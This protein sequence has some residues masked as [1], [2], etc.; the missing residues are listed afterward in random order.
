MAFPLALLDSFTQPALAAMVERVFG[1]PDW[2][3]RLIGHPVGWM[4]RFI[5]M[6]DTKMNTTPHLRGLS[7][8]NGILAMVLLCLGVFAVASVL[9][10]LCRAL[11]YG[12][13]LNA[14]LATSLIATKSLRSHVLA[15]SR[16]LSSSLA[17]GRMAVSKIV[18]RETRQLDVSGVSKAALESLAENTADGIVAPIFWYCVFGLPGL[19]VYKAI[20]TADSMIGHKSPQYRYFGWAAA[21]LDDLVNLPASRISALLFIT[22]ALFS[23]K[24]GAAWNALKSVW[25]DASKHRSPNAGWPESAMAGALGLQFGGPR[26]YGNEVVNLPTMGRG[27]DHLLRQDIADGIKLFDNAMWIMMGLLLAFALIL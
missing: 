12:F 1:Y 2:L 22:A 11:P 27:R 25:R 6:L 5:T 26:A 24:K 16:A 19:A 14:I 20:N 15:V 4:G 3:Y 8:M 18:G 23:P 13:I 10:F 7:R 9:H 17:D 21:R